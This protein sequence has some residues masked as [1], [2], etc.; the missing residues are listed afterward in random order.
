[1]TLH[2]SGELSTSGRQMCTLPGC[3]GP[4]Y[5]RNANPEKIWVQESMGWGEQTSFP[6]KNAEYQKTCW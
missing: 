1:M 5:S 3:R 4:G 2:C 6:G